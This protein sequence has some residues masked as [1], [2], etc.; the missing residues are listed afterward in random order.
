[1]YKY[2]W[3]FNYGNGKG[4]AKTNIAQIVNEFGVP[5]TIIEVGVFE[6]STTFWMNDE[7]VPHNPN[8][9]IYAV[10]PHV[11]SIDVSTCTKISTLSRKT[12]ITI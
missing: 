7:L 12:L 10:D 5:N 9:K 1:M 3:D 2:T 8:L 4:G 6:G 11:G